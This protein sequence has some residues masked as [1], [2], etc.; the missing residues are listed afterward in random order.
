MVDFGELKGKADRCTVD[1]LLHQ[2]RHQ[3]VVT[4][5]SI[6]ATPRS[7]FETLTNHITRSLFEAGGL[8]NLLHRRLG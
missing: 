1:L 3:I 2:G 5:L 7:G 6:Y 4:G 8:K